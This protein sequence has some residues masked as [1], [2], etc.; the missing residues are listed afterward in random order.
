M[1]KL[2]KNNLLVFYFLVIF[3]LICSVYVFFNLPIVDTQPVYY[4]LAKSLL[5]KN[6]IIDEAYDGEHIKNFY[7]FGY[8]AFI[9]GYIFGDIDMTLR[10]IQFFSLMSVYVITLY[11]HSKTKNFELFIGNHFSDRNFW[12]IFFW[13]FFLLFHPYF[14][15]NITRVTDTTLALFCI[16]IL[17]SLIV[18]RF[19]YNKIYIFIAGFVLGLFIGIR[20]NSI[21]LLLLF[22]YFLYKN[23]I[24]KSQY[25]IFLLTTFFTYILFSHLITGEL[26]FWPS[27]GGYTLFAG[28]NPFS[29]SATKVFYNSERSIGQAIEWCGIIGR[30]YYSI[31]LTDYLNCT[32]KFFLNDFFGFCKNFI[33]KIYNLFFRPNLNPESLISAQGIN[34]GIVEIFFKILIVIPAYIWWIL[35]IFNRN[36]RNSFSVWYGALFIF[37]YCFL[38]IISLTDPRHSLPIDIIYIISSLNYKFK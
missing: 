16:T 19:N 32:Q 17:F 21:L 22:V 25:L 9:S 23:Y 26:F 8:P 1:E 37:T 18:N 31:S 34:L 33:F 5:N 30:D 14:I 38:S 13:V 2:K 20:P 4:E 10:V 11:N 28:N 24:C 27:Q 29:Y 35:F 36:F 6:Y 12:W 7:S 15:L 3:S